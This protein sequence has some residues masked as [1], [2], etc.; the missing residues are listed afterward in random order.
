VEARGVSRRALAPL[1]LGGA[2]VFVY[3]DVGEGGGGDPRYAVTRAQLA[4]HLDQIR[5]GGYS[6]VPLTRIW[7]GP[8]GGA[9]PAVALT[10]DDG[11]ASDYRHAYPLLMEHGFVGEFFV[12]P[13]TIGR[14]GYLSW[15]EA[16]EMSRAGMRFQSHAHD[17]LYL[18]L[19]SAALLERQVL[20]SKRRIEDELGCAVQFMAAPYGDAN[21]RVRQAALAAGYQAVCTSWD[22]PARAGRPTVSRVAVYARTTTAELARLLRGD[23]L[24]YLRRATRSALLYP[25]KRAVLSLWPARLTDRAMEGTA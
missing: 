23:P 3:H 1:R 25:A 20:D 4:G 18:T 17:H 6:V 13:G 10:F 11:R 19:L 9:A 16:R 2:R 22:W 21:R 24:P 7:S 5:R 14:A 15:G 8:E 12:N